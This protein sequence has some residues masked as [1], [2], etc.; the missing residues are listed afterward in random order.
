MAQLVRSRSRYLNKLRIITRAD[1][2]RLFIILVSKADVIFQKPFSPNDGHKLRPRERS[3]C[4]VVIN[5]IFYRSCLSR[6]ASTFAPGPRGT[7]SREEKKQRR[8]EEA[9]RNPPSSHGYHVGLMYHRK[10]LT[11]VAIWK[12]FAS[13]ANR[14]INL[15]PCLHRTNL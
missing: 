8:K 2:V 12:C 15:A 10:H 4:P 1:T 3:A 5:V 11:I 14:R 13:P 6:R 7:R 9:F